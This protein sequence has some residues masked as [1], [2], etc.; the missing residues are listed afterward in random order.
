MWETA[1]V[2]GA[3]IAAGAAS[4]WAA[5]TIN[6]HQ[7]SGHI[8]TTEAGT[9]WA[10]SERFRKAQESRIDKLEKRIE[11]LEED[12]RKCHDALN[13]LLNSR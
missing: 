5:I 8:D 1:G 9:L 7:N 3:A 6:R 2:V 11:E 13:T 4:A 10:A 12:N